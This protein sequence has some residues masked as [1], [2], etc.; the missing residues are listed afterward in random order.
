MS[1]YP[2]YISQMVEDVR[3]RLLAKRVPGRLIVAET[4]EQDIDENFI[5]NM[6]VGTVEC[7]DCEGTGW[8]WDDTACG[9]PDHCS[10]QYAC[11]T[12]NP[13]GRDE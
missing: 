4:L 12:C 10:P 8:I 7:P 3:R 5:L 1:E 2:E 13:E 6:S 11:P 9:D